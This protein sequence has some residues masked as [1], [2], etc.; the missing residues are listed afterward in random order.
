MTSGQH[1]WVEVDFQ[2]RPLD[3]WTE[4]P[5]AKNSRSDPPPGTVVLP[6]TITVHRRPLMDQKQLVINRYLTS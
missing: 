6:Y 3:P 5:R 1:F 4:E 2:L